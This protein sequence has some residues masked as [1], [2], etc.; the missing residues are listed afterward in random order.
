MFTIQHLMK[1]V[2]IDKDG[3]NIGLILCKDKDG[4]TFEYALKDIN[5]P[6]GVST[7]KG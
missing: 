6:I 1:N 5:K 7:Y 4:F 2:Q 3:S